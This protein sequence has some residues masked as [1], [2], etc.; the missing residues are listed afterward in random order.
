MIKAVL[1]RGV[2]SKL[3]PHRS[4]ASMERDGGGSSEEQRFQEGAHLCVKM[5]SGCGGLCG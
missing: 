4:R 1:K 3:G 2:Q 5:Q